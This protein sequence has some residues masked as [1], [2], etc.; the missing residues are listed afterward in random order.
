M[1]NE[2]D[3]QKADGG[4]DT[5]FGSPA[6]CA[7]AI[8]FRILGPVEAWAGEHQIE[9]GGPRQLA[10]L[11]CLLLHANRAV[12]SDAIV[13][14]VWPR[15][16]SG[17]GKRL[18]MAIAR[19]RKA[20][21]QVNETGSSRLQT[22]NGG[23]LL[24]IGPDELDAEVFSAGVH[25]GRRALDQG[26]A[27]RAVDVLGSALALWRGTPLAQLYYEDFA[28]ARIRHIEELRVLALETRAEAEL[29]LGRHVQLIAELEELITE[30]PGRERAASQLMLALY[31]AGRQ[32]DALEVYH[33]I[34]THL[35]AASGLEPGPALR[36]IQLQILRQ[37]P[38]LERTHTQVHGSS[39]RMRGAVGGAESSRQ[40]QG[41]PVAVRWASFTSSSSSQI[42]FAQMASSTP[43]I[44]LAPQQLPERR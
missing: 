16:R 11:A 25:A 7:A 39:M 17:T 6:R 1:L 36:T 4:G 30:H 10:L 8:T 24:S 13:D 34:R 3:V 5:R 43:S 15:S 40:S 32:S 22:V 31:R 19:L 18:A 12:S 14:A 28:Q 2:R 37:S 20:L 35:A 44:G 21:S 41:I 9:L 26:D 33:R 38:E 23:Y 29:Q 27:A 42:L